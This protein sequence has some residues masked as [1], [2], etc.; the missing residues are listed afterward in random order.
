MLQNKR[1][2]ESGNVFVI[3][4]VAV[5]LFTLLM[6][7][8]TRTGSQGTG[9]LTKQQSRIAAQ[10]ILNYARLIESSVDKLRLNGCSESE[11]SFENSIE[12]GYVNAGAPGD[13]SCDIFHEDGGRLEWTT[14]SN[15]TTDNSEWLISPS[16]A[17]VNIGS[18]S[19]ANDC[20]ANSCTELALFLGPLESNVCNNINKLVNAPTATTEAMAGYGT[21][22][23]GSYTNTG[24]LG[25]ASTTYR[26]VSTACLDGNGSPTGLY[27]YHVLLA[28]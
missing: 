14:A 7:T 8:F 25:D 21:K 26:N 12:A 28:R 6:F 18:D 20:S 27:F 23:T 2:R 9:N 3:I 22:F 5:A 13:N 16:I 19:G 10:E 11:I 1:F 17:I 24:Q 15:Y 4:L